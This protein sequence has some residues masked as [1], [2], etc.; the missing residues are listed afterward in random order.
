MA[1]VRKC[2]SGFSSSLISAIGKDRSQP[3]ELLLLLFFFCWQLIRQKR[4]SIDVN[5]FVSTVM[6]S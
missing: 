5:K 6:E 1:I 4:K 3:S 2:K